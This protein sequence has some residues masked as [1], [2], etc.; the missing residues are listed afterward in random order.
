LNPFKIQTSFNPGFASEICN[1]KS[2]EILELG[3]KVKLFYFKLSSTLPS[4]IIFGQQEVCV[5]DF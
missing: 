5:L 4:C 1:P 2:G 3:Q